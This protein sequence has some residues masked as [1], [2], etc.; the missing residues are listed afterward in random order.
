MN[1]FVYFSPM[2]IIWVKPPCISAYVLK[3][4]PQGSGNSWFN[5][6]F[7]RKLC[8]G[9]RN[10]IL[11]LCKNYSFHLHDVFYKCFVRDLDVPKM[12]AYFWWFRT[13]PYHF[14]CISNYKHYIGASSNQ[15]KWIYRRSW[16]KEKN[17]RFDLRR[18]DNTDS[19]LASTMVNVLL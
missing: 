1:I 4:K 11:K 14:L 7:K 6:D 13:Y 12:S 18:R 3:E 8:A 17:R 16:R 15:N 5:L 19:T 9:S 2:Y 10:M